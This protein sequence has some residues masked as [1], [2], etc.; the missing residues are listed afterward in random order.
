[1]RPCF[2]SVSVAAA[3]LALAA[4][5][6]ESSALAP[7]VDGGGTDVQDTSE[8]D[9]GEADAGGA[10]ASEGQD[11]SEQDADDAGGSTTAPGCG[12]SPE[13]IEQ[14]LDVN[15]KTRTFELYV[16][17]DYDP[18]RSY[19]VVLA[20]HGGGG[21][22]AGFRSDSG[23]DEAVGSDAI[24]V[25]PDGLPPFA[26][27]DTGWILDPAGDGFAFFDILMAHLTDNLCVDSARVYVT[28]WSFGGYMAN[29]LACY[30]DDVVSAVVSVAGGVPSE[31]PPAPPYPACVAQVPSM[32]F[33]GAADAVIPPEFG[34]EMRD[35]FVAN[36]ECSS[37]ST[38]TD[39][40]PC[41]AYDDCLEPTLWCEYDG[42]HA[43]PDTYAGAAWAFFAAL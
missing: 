4:C 5:S 18:S 27:G 12:S 31:K 39:P 17:G 15:G 32:L 42:G 3:A 33:H 26:G 13:G 19:P 28:G 43:W 9:A 38:A 25:Y 11:V 16:P 37:T 36:N 41:V 1:M 30:R 21:S 24:V 7:R 14:A 23:F 10:D 34:A 29:S 40:S 22:G 8:G 20:L 6:D 2:F 35:V